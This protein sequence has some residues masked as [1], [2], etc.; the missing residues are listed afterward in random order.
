MRSSQMTLAF[1]EELFA[2]LK[3]KML[4]TSGIRGALLLSPDEFH[5]GLCTQTPI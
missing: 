5:W 4:S 3:V 2:L 1:G